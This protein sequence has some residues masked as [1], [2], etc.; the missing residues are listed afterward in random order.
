MDGLMSL[1]SEFRPFCGQRCPYLWRTEPGPGGKA[2]SD[3][4]TGACSRRRKP[5]ILLTAWMLD[6]SVA[7][8]WFG[9]FFMFPYIG[10]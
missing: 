3:L 8:W 5:W 2:E 4:K 7:D 9:I 6:D 1:M 10:N